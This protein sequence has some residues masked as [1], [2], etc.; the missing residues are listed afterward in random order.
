MFDYFF[1][2]WP[3]A[4]VGAGSF[5]NYQADLKPDSPE[6]QMRVDSQHKVCQCFVCSCV[7]AC[8]HSC[9]RACMC[10]CVCVRMCVCV[11]LCVCMRLSL[12]VC[13][14]KSFMDQPN[15]K[16]LSIGDLNQLKVICMYKKGQSLLSLVYEMCFQCKTETDQ[17]ES[18]F[19][20]FFFIL[21]KVCSIGNH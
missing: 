9:V 6:F 18:S 12:I 14:G 19:I 4:I 20:S 3:R 11:Y 17:D 7:C 21:L 13:L 2:I 16:G 5:W 8:M 10:V 15:L 1:Q